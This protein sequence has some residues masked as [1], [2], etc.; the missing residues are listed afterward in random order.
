MSANNMIDVTLDN[1]P[2][3]HKANQF[4]IGMLDMPFR[5]RYI[6]R[7][8]IRAVH[9]WSYGDGQSATK[10]E[11]ENKTYYVEEPVKSVVFNIGRC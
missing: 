11:C 4:D 1:I 2:D 7:N 6:N 5:K 10:I 8:Y 9:K 3:E